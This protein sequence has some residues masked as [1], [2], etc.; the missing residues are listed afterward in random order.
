M[1]D[2]ETIHRTVTVRLRRKIITYQHQDVELKFTDAD[3][4]KVREIQDGTPVSADEIEAYA[5]EEAELLDKPDQWVETKPDAF[6]ELD[7]EIEDADPPL[8]T[9]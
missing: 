8:P 1:T 2:P 7:S 4:R 5:F 3:V 9:E 6:E